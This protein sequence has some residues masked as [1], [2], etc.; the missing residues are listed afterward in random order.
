MLLAGGTTSAP[1]SDEAVSFVHRDIRIAGKPA[2]ADHSYDIDLVG[3]ATGAHLIRDALDILIEGSPFNA[4]AIDRLKANGNVIIMYDPAFPRRELSQVTIA[5]FFPDFFRRDGRSKDFVTVVGRYGGK[6]SPRDLAPVLAHE[7]TGHGI[8]HLRGRLQHVRVVDLECEA[9]L[10]Q[11][12][13]YQDLGFDKGTRDMI[14]FR[15]QL[16]RHWCADFRTWQRAARPEGAL[17]WDQLNPDVARLLK[18][19]L[20]YI[21][22][23]RETGVAGRAVDRAAKVQSEATRKRIAALQAS[24][25]PED[26][27]QLAQMYLRGI[28]IDPD[29]TEGARWLREAA[30]A[31][32][33]QAQYQLARAYWIGKGL[34]VDK[35]AGARWTR[36]AAENGHTGAAYVY[37]AMLVNG[38][39]VARDRE[40]GIAWITRAAEA[41]HA[42]AKKALEQLN[43]QR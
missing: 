41:G 23:L 30:Q 21:E 15:Q 29:D 43:N 7:L 17:Y 27:F 36:R 10:Y 5:A 42:S 12:K 16:E 25:E 8:Q 4:A 40:A 34:G 14:S 37:G 33:A 9:Y 39:G 22:H 35:A 32:H 28:G 38:D 6:W 31:G 3:P 1:A 18:D 11:E 19:Y 13:A 24:T 20:D 26:H 2:A